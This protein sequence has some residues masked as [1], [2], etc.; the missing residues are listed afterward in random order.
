MSRGRLG[1]LV[2]LAIVGAADTRSHRGD[3][4]VFAAR[5]GSAGIR[6]VRQRST[7]ATREGRRRRAVAQLLHGFSREFDERSRA[8]V[9]KQRIP[10]Q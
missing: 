5:L 6:R 4:P 9:L 8:S 2:V 7:G 1:G 10:G 3:P